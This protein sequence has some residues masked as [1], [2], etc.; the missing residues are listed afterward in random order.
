MSEKP[1]LPCP[2]IQRVERVYVAWVNSDLNEG[3]G[4]QIPLV[5]SQYQ[6]T[7]KRLGMRQNVQGCDAI[8][9]EDYALLLQG[10]NGIFYVPGTITPPSEEDLKLFKASEEKEKAK[11]IFDEVVERAKLAGLSEDD[12]KVLRSAPFKL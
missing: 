10:G 2:Q 1:L 6:E 12:I 11:K 9:K 4:R 3:R 7:A 8:V 5:V